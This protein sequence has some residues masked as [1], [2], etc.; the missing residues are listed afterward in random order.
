ME[1]VICSY[2]YNEECSQIVLT[3]FNRFPKQ[4][5]VCFVT[6]IEYCRDA[7]RLSW[8]KVELQITRDVNRKNRE[9]VKGA[10]NLT[11]S[12]RFIYVHGLNTFTSGTLSIIAFA[13]IDCL[14]A[15]AI[16]NDVHLQYS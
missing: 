15:N 14:A 11:M 13:H 5:I 7:K 10:N 16:S 6:N 4:R 1:T 9:C 2:D 3:H 12:L 8:K